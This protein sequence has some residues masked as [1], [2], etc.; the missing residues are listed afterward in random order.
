MVRTWLYAGA[1]FAVLGAA[2]F[3]IFIRLPTLEAAGIYRKVQPMNYENC[4]RISELKACEKIKI[5]P[6]GMMYLA[7]AGTIESRITWMPTLDALD[8]TAAHSKSTH[9]YL[10]TYN[11]HTGKITKLD[12]RGMVD[13]RGLNLHGMDVVPDEKD[14][15]T[16]WIYLVNHRPPLDPTYIGANSVIEVFK[17]QLGMG[18]VDWVQTVEDHTVVV[19]PND[20]VGS[21]NGQEFWFTND[22]SVKTGMWRHIDGN[23]LRKTTFVGYCHLKH[24]CKRASVPLIGVNGI[25]QARYSASDGSILVGSYRLG[26]LT[27]HKPKHDKTLEHVKTVDTGLPLDNLAVSADGS[28]IAAAFPKAHLIF[29]AARNSNITAPSG[30]LRLQKNSS[31]FEKLY[32]DDG[33]LGSFATTAAMYEDTL[34]IHVPAGLGL[35]AA[36]TARSAGVQLGPPAKRACPLSPTQ[37]GEKRSKAEARC[38]VTAKRAG[39]GPGWGWAPETARLVQNPL[40]GGQTTRP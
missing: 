6:S 18:H 3:Q 4:Q 16:L 23:F 9:D 10:A 26:Q 21:S 22:N 35:G 31:K 15:D 8:S 40:N 38:R 28:I 37:E 34:F 30:V 36:A 24:G 5:L 25:V 19:T 11:I 33:Q 7:C 39:G 14:P 12:V 20:I 32:E 29:P 17:T 2:W 1:T 13:P 27:V